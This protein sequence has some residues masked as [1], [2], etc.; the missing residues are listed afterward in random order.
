MA[1]A[2]AVIGAIMGGLL[3]WLALTKVTER[4][5]K[6]E[7]ATTLTMTF[8]HRYSE[9]SFVAIRDEVDTFL[10][11]IRPYTA[12]EKIAAARE[13]CRRQDADAIQLYNRLHAVGMFFAE[14]GVGFAMGLIDVRGLAIF[15]RLLPQY[16]NEMAPFIVAAHIEFGF[17]VDPTSP[18]VLQ[19]LA[20]FNQFRY[21]YGAMTE[22][23]IAREPTVLEAGTDGSE[24]RGVEG[25]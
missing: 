5:T 18:L 9:P 10:A 11:R 13:V 7:L 19:D 12:E 17:E 15:D 4:Q 14:I 1:L 22:Q 23:G 21:A 8:M 25:A 2:S 3:S 24:R 16:W 6:T 20:L